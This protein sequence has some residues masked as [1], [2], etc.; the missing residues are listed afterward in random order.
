VSRSISL[1]EQVQVDQ[2]TARY[3]NGV[4]TVSLPQKEE[5]KPRQ[6]TIDVK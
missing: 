1:P 6:I 5:A 2:I 3:E 4:L